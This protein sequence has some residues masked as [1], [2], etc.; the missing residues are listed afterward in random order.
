MLL[1]R[2]EAYTTDKDLIE[3]Q[4]FEEKCKNSYNNL[5][6]EE[7]EKFETM[8][9]ERKKWLE[10]AKTIQKITPLSIFALIEKKVAENKG[11]KIPTVEELKDKWKNFTDKKRYY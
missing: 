4:D 10:N 3:T 5:T 11:E 2:T 7:K 9:K 6:E 1:K 8:A